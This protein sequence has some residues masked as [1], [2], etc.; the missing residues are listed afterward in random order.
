[1]TKYLTSIPQIVQMMDFLSE[2]STLYEVEPGPE[3]RLIASNSKARLLGAAP[4]TFYGQLMSDFLPK[5]F[6]RNTLLPIV[7]QVITSKQSFR[8]KHITPYPGGVQL[9]DCLVTPVI[10]NDKCTHIWVITKHQR[11]DEDLESLSF[12]DE[13]TKVSNRRFILERLSKSF[14]RYIEQEIEFSIMLIDLDN[15]KTINDTKGHQ[16]GDN[17]LKNIARRMSSCIR[18]SDLI[19]RLGGDEF[20]ILAEGQG[21]QTIVFDIAQ[22]LLEKT[23][24]P[25]NIEGSNLS[26]TLS[27]GIAHSGAHPSTESMLADADNAMYKAKL[28]G[29]IG[30]W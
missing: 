23:R 27:I 10:E 14:K 18:D 8:G 24:E 12:T 11:T 5:D 30:M 1:M 6:Y 15:F 22:R 20:V 13:L 3:F 17:L 21:S 4:S 29:V 19:G 7:T 9:M 25:F 26:I 2:I 28:L 16:F